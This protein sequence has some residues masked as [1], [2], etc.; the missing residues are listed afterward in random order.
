MDIDLPS[1]LLR[2]RAGS[3]ASQ[4]P[5]RN[6]PNAPAV[7]KIGL[8][9]YT[10]AATS[11]LLFTVAQRLTGF[12]GSLA[13][14]LSKDQAWLRMPAITGW[15][16]SKDFPTPATKPFH[17][18]LPAQVHADQDGGDPNGIITA[19]PPDDLSN[20]EPDRPGKAEVLQK[21]SSELEALGA[22]FQAC[23][24]GDTAQIVLDILGRHG[25][26]EILTWQE[27]HLP[28]GILEKMAQAG[29]RVSHPAVET[30]QEASHIRAG[31]SGACAGIADTGSL[32]LLGGPGQPLTVSL[33]PEIHIALLREQDVFERLDQVLP[34]EAI[35]CSSAAV[36]VTGPSRTA[37]IE[38]TLTIGVH[39]PGELHV[40]CLRDE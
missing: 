4:P 12:F 16:Y 37:D 11:P 34:Q 10:L 15:G 25:I 5:R 8:G 30:L 32:V 20:L 31:L 19:P 28:G 22:N 35:K 26:T 7:L 38:M 33:L 1:L 9:L 29:I 27:A 23:L 2:V 14:K 39:G 21:F 18:R 6:K 24:P 3:G 13:T 36:V 17:T 40:I